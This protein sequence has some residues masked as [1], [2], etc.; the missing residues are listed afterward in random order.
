MKPAGTRAAGKQRIHDLAVRRGRAH[1]AP[2][3][4]WKTRAPGE[5]TVCEGCGG[6]FLRKTWHRTPVRVTHA[7]L[8]RAAWGV[9][10]AC[11]QVRTG[12]FF[13]RVVVRGSYLA[14]HEAEIR[15]RI[16]NVAERAQYT[17]PERRLVAVQRRAAELVVLTTSQKL[18]HR[19]V[20]ELKKAFKGRAQYAWSDRERRLQAVWER[21]EP[22]DATAA[23]RA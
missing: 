12:V 15:R 18:A 6:A 4:K 9:C 22:E 13:G 10:P 16:R 17:Q 20:H 2:A 5:A 11:R 7:L 23:A 21:N 14:G 1:Q 3:P 19:I 8:M